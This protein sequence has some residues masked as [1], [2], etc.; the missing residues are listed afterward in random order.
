MSVANEGGNLR[1]KNL[2]WISIVA[3]L[4]FSMLL[5]QSQA[6]NEQVVVEII[7][8]TSTVP[9]VGDPY[10]INVT[11][12]DVTDLF[13]WELKIYYPN[14]ILNGTSVTQGTFLTENGAVST[15]FY[16]A[17]Y[18]PG[19]GES[20]FR[21]NYNT[22]HG[23]VYCLST[24]LPPPLNGVDGSGVLVTIDFASTA[25]NGPLDLDLTDVKLRDS[26]AAVI[27]VSATNDGEVTVIPEF[28]AFLILPSFMAASLVAAILGKK[29][30]SRK[31]R[32]SIAV[33]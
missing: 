1:K 13:G 29:V 15:F 18:P 24:R 32:I 8:A 11:I 6:A 27:P 25:E 4:L 12:A 16:V 3:L 9:N 28:P 33:K 19:S 10:T 26:T 20:G 30:W 5:A 2:F 14:S 23:I 31:R 7:P 21:D 22:T 17:E